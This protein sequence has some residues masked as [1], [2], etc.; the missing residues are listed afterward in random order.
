MSGA[1][2]TPATPQQSQIQNTSTILVYAHILWTYQEPKIQFWL[3]DDFWPD[4]V[5]LNI[6][7]VVCTKMFLCFYKIICIYFFHLLIY[8]HYIFS[9]NILYSRIVYDLSVFSGGGRGVVVVGI[10]SGC[11]NIMLG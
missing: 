7:F 8:N 5:D 9:V 1:F 10:T 4:C 2:S 6:N 3:L 11:S